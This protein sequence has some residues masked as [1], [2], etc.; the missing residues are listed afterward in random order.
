MSELEKIIRVAK[1]FDEPDIYLILDA[2][3][4]QNALVQAKAFSELAGL[5]G[6]FLTKLDSTAKGGIAISIADETQ[7]PILYVGVGEGQDDLVAFDASE[8]ARSI[9]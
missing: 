3:T 6:I 1:N 2:N 5:A 4:G 9:V 7:T 8:F